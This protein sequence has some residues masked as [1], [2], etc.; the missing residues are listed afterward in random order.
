MAT[1]YNSDM[2]LIAPFLNIALR[3]IIGL[4]MDNVILSYL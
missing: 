3:C 1:P 4:I 2:E